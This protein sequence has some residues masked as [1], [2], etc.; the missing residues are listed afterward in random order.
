M[1]DRYADGYK[2]FALE[3]DLRE[4]IF[5]YGALG[6][7]VN[8]FPVIYTN[9]R[10]DVTTD[11]GNIHAYEY[12]KQVGDKNWLNFVSSTISVN[13]LY[14]YRS[15]LYKDRKEYQHEHEWRMLY[16]NLKEE[17]D[18]I[19]IKDVGCLKAIYYGPDITL[20][21]KDELHTIAIKKGLKEYD[22]NLDTSSR[23]YDLKVI[24]IN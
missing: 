8:L 7:N 4:C 14:W 16:Y 18:Y 13:Q 10:P 9:L 24:A 12:F 23:K 22:V 5:K 20:K 17:K 15:Y 1:W 19:S 3:Y 2:G 11:E 6:M 21:N